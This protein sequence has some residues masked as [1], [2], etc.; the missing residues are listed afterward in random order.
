MC[1]THRQKSILTWWSIKKIELQN[2]NIRKIQRFQVKNTPGKRSSL[3]F[4]NCFIKEVIPEDCQGVQ[5]IT[6]SR[7]RS[8]STSSTLVSLHSGTPQWN[9]NRST[10]SQIAY[11]IFM[12]TRV[13]NHYYSWVSI[14]YIW[15][16]LVFRYFLGYS[17]IKITPR[18]LQVSYLAKWNKIIKTIVIC[19]L[20]NLNNIKRIHSTWWVILSLLHIP[21]INYIPVTKKR[22]IWE[23]YRS[24][25]CQ[26]VI[27]KFA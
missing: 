13:R 11:R 26:N 8:T 25:Y 19:L 21:W 27:W 23:C 10:K 5:S 12:K 1:I 9:R 18:Q 17:Y 24:T 3:Y 16:G 20:A 2:V 7:S 6:F 4:R 14:S 22:L 15:W